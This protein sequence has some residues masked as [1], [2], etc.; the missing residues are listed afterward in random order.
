MG[1][2]HLF[3]QQIEQVLRG[4]LGFEKLRTTDSQIALR[5]LGG[6][7]EYA[8]Y[9]QRPGQPLKL[10]DS[11][12]FSLQSIQTV[13]THKGNINESS[14]N[15]ETLFDSNNRELQ[16]MMGVLLR[17]PELRENLEQVTGGDGPDGDK[18]AS[19]IKDWVCGASISEIAESYFKKENEDKITALTKCGQNLFGKL[20]QTASWGLGA[21]LSITGENLDEGN[22]KNLRNLPSWVFYG[23]NNNES[24]ALRLLG[25]PRSA[26]TPLTNHLGV[27]LEE[28]LPQMRNILVELTEND[29]KKAMGENGG[30][31]RKVWRIL[32]GIEK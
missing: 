28:S 4:T 20:T 11:T 27:H 29:W 9:L 22:M 18:L 19:I 10:V 1:D 24:I 8:Q 30:T 21:L 32:E 7:E 26:A 12:G 15:A 17:V 14:W 13:L 6:I 25:I 16:D 3:S 5:L 31:Y 2:P 23:V